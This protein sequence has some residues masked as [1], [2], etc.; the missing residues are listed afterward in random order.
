MILNQSE[1]LNGVLNIVHG[2]SITAFVA[3]I[4]YKVSNYFMKRRKKGETF[5]TVLAPK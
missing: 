4:F 3:A 1:S 2:L 5:P